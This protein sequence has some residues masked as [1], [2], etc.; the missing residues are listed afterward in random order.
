MPEFWNECLI[1]GIVNVFSRMVGRS[2]RKEETRVFG[3][4]EANSVHK[5]HLLVMFPLP[6]AAYIKGLDQVG[7]VRRVFHYP[8]LIHLSCN[9]ELVG[10]WHVA[11]VRN[12]YA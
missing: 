3:L 4:K 2:Q 1:V 6:E 11:P 10:F 12:R 8:D 9:N 7:L 5:S